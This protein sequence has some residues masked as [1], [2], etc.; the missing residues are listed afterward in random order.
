MRTGIAHTRLESIASGA[1]N[2]YSLMQV[3]G[4]GH[5][6]T[7]SG[8]TVYVTRCQTT[9]VTHRT[10]TNCT[11]KIPVELNSIHL[12]VDPVSIVNKA[13]AAR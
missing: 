10:H 9:E 4:K 13:A 11:N 5:Q 8:S 7:H 3:L 1:K 2:P 6:V 12:F